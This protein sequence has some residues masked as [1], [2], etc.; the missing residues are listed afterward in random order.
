MYYSLNIQLICTS[1]SLFILSKII[2]MSKSSSP[3]V[4]RVKMWQGSGSRPA[5]VICVLGQPM[6]FV[7]SGAQSITRQRL[8]AKYNFNNQT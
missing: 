1:S 6:G 3:M 8:V 2:I 7:I 4:D 5:S